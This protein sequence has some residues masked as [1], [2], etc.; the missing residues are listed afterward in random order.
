TTLAW[1]GLAGGPRRG[2]SLGRGVP[3]ARGRGAGRH[4]GPPGG[5]RRIPARATAALPGRRRSAAGRLPRFRPGADVVV[6]F[7]APRRAAGLPAPPLRRLAAPPGE[8]GRGRAAARRRLRPRRA[9]PPDPRLA[10]RG[11]DR[12]PVR[13]GAAAGRVRGVRSHAVTVAAAAGVEVI[14]A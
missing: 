7:P 9:R 13:R 10:Q 8:R 12:T 14:L 4:A 3:R 6:V 2:D 11:A 5:P 1:S